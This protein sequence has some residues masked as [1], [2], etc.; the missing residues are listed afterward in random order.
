MRY[1]VFLAYKP[2]T[3]ESGHSSKPNLQILGHMWTVM[4]PDIRGL[5]KHSRNAHVLQFHIN[6]AG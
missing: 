2:R 5:N 1:H 4:Q 3:H 6:I